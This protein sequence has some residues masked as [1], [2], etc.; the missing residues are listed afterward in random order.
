MITVAYNS[1]VP[2][3]LSVGDIAYLKRKRSDVFSR[4][5]EMGMISRGGGM[6]GTR[7]DE[8]VPENIW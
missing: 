2:Q 5:T 8:N 1:G 7:T 4:V 6:K 3:F